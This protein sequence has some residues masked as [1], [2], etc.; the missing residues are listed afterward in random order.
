[1]TMFSTIATDHG[2]EYLVPGQK[3]T[4]SID[5]VS[6]MMALVLGTSGLPHI[7]MRFFT[8]KDAKQH[9]LQLTGQLGLQPYSSH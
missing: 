7:L 9:V 3:Y 5:S 8:V 2:E 1:M 6:M 4:S